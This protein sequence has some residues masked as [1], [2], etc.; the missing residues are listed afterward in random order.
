MATPLTSH[1]PLQ[2]RT[3]VGGLSSGQGLWD[4]LL[5]SGQGR[6]PVLR[7]H[8][9]PEKVL[10]RRLVRSS[11]L[12]APGFRETWRVGGTKGTHRGRAPVLGLRGAPCPPLHK[13]CWDAI[14]ATPPCLGAPHSLTGSPGHQRASGQSRQAFPHPLEAQALGAGG[15]CA[16]LSPGD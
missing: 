13:S 4:R 3:W 14:G 9:R 6:R 8:P 2:I 11:F 7:L 1:I 12:G 5:Q 16:S 15:V 10:R